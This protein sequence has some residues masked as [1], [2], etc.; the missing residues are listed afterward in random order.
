M[1]SLRISSPEVKN[2][3][4]GDDEDVAGGMKKGSS[5]PRPEL[6][7]LCQQTPYKGPFRPCFS[8]VSALNRCR[9]PVGVMNEAGSVEKGMATEFITGL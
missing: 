8:G 7:A 3:P 6:P 1:L 2:V 4:N 9:T 5:Q